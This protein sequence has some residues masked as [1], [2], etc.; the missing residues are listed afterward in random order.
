ML[1]SLGWLEFSVLLPQLQRC[2]DFREATTSGYFVD[3]SL[4]SFFEVWQSFTGLYVQG[5]PGLHSKASSQMHT[6]TCTHS[7]LSKKNI[8]N[9][10]SDIIPCC[11][12]HLASLVIVFAVF[13]YILSLFHFCCPSSNLH[14]SFLTVVTNH[15]VDN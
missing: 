5:Q 8:A 12:D 14:P 9:D 7:H 1:S 10:F 6:H 2:W 3:F 11:V 13:L 4:Q 15:T